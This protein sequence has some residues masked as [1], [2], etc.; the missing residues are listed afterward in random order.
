MY[1]FVTNECSISHNLT[2][3]KLSP[4]DWLL[5]S[6]QPLLAW[7]KTTV[8]HRHFFFMIWSKAIVCKHVHVLAF[9]MSRD[10]ACFI[11][12]CDEK[13][14]LLFVEVVFVCVYV[15]VCVCLRGADVK[16][17]GTIALIQWNGGSN[18]YGRRKECVCLS[19]YVLCNMT[20]TDSDTHTL[21]HRLSRDLSRSRLQVP[22][23][24]Y[25]QKIVDT[26]QS[27]WPLWRR[28]SSNW[29]TRSVTLQR[30]LLWQR[31]LVA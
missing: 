4:I 30:R 10:K 29:S 5:Q 28:K 31:S 3:L 8:A 11:L 15:C 25:S 9:S 12:C 19:L 13:K 7:N 17:A 26:L 24:Q 18:K 23:V 16:R 20:H 1:V 14:F 27:T 21:A 6:V 2:C 22:E